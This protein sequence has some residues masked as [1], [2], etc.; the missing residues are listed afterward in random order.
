MG[1][2]PAMAIF[3]VSS[4]PPKYLSF[5]LKPQ[6]GY[7]FFTFLSIKQPRNPQQKRGNFRGKE[8]FRGKREVAFFLIWAAR[9]FL[10][11]R[12][13]KI[14]TGDAHERLGEREGVSNH[15]K[16]NHA[17]TLAILGTTQKST[18]YIHRI[19]STILVGAECFV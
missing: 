11:K 1:V 3:W 15:N 13:Y 17:H 7:A 2:S 6:R 4:K 16:K 14:S 8:Y 5:R 19:S 18:Q 9:A 10:K 12:R